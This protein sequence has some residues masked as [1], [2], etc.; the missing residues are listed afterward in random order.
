MGL[1]VR[2]SAGAVIGSL[3]AGGLNV[4]QLTDAFPVG[5]ENAV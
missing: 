2:A 1:P 5:A 3:A 4:A